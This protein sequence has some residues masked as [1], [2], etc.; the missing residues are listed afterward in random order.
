M[1]D[2][3]QP[4]ALHHYRQHIKS[5][6][7]A[8]SSHYLVIG[9]WD[10]SGTRIPRVKFCGIEAGPSSLS[11]L[12][13]LQREW[14]SWTMGSG[15]KPDFLR[16]HVAYYVLG[17]DVW[18][19]AP[20][21]EEVTQRYE[22][23]YLGSTQNPTDLS[24]AGR[25]LHAAPTGDAEPDRYFYDPHDTSM[26]ALESAV[27][28]ENRTDQS[29]F[30]AASGRH[31]IYQSERFA[32]AAEISGFFSASFWLG[33]DRPDTDFRACVYDIGPDGSSL[34]LTS[35]WLRARYRES[36]RREVLITDDAP[37][38]YDFDRFTFVSRRVR[39]GHRLRLAFGPFDSIHIQRNFNGGGVPVRES[40]RDARS[41]TVRLFHDEAHPSVLRVP[42]A[43]PRA[44]GP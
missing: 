23:L 18:R 6:P 37:L 21:L 13:Q 12:Q 10:H 5:A 32:R 34:L 2:G 31:L 40:L 15:S 38:R 28:T 17:A 39:A 4:G 36:F 22:S 41:V 30:H 33:I 9:P 8:Q 29:L 16:D 14:Y 3:N 24:S 1:C 42:F 44:Q 25:L 43:R 26:A 20:S 19:Y 35:D 7:E 27:D 11:D